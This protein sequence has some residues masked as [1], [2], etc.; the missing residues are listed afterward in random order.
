[1]NTADT[2]IHAQWYGFY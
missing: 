1:M 2:L